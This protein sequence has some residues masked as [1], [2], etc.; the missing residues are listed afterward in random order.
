MKKAKSALQPYAVF[1]PNQNPLSPSFE[2][3]GLGRIT[4]FQP[5]VPTVLINASQ[6]NG[7]PL[8]VRRNWHPA[9]SGLYAVEYWS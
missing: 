6:D 9:K 5:V 1:Y 3:G 8:P 7:Y 2:K 4:Q